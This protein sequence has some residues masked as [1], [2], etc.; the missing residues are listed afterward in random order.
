MTTRRTFLTAGLAGTATALLAACGAAATPTPV[1]PKPTEPPKPAAPA[2]PPT[3]APA[4]TKPAE[5][6]KPAAAVPAA[7]APTKP[8]D[9]AAK[10]TEAAKP[11]AAPQPAAAAPKPNPGPTGEW[12]FLSHSQTE[13]YRKWTDRFFAQAFPNLKVR[14]DI[15]PGLD[16]YFAKLQTLFAANEPFDFMLNHESR[17]QALASKG[18]LL[19]LDDYR[20]GRPFHVPEA[21]LFTTPLPG[22]SWAGKLYGWPC[23][24]STNGVVYNKT[25]LGKGNA[26]L[27]TDTWTV[28]D[29]A[30]MA[31]KATIDTNGDGRPDTWGITDWGERS[32]LFTWYALLR[33]FGGDHF[34]TDGEKAIINE[35]GGVATLEYMRELYCTRKGLAPASMIAQMG[36]DGIAPFRGGV[37]AFFT[38]ANA[39]GQEQTHDAAKKAGFEWGVALPPAGPAGQFSRVGGSSWSIP[40]FSRFPEPSWDFARHHVSD[41]PTVQEIASEARMTVPHFATFEKYLGPTGETKEYLGESWKKVFV[42]NPRKNGVV[43]NYSRIGVEY[44]PMVNAELSSLADCSK[45]AKQVADAIAQKAQKAL[46]DSK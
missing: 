38:A 32:S 36:S 19:P 21:E 7:P 29:M 39:G 27:P 16:Q 34:S 31:V 30:D 4:A 3:T 22:L 43:M 2:A 10:P 6:T 1:P 41:L 5:P 25:L 23:N 46:A 26:G 33:N 17:A 12:V 18:V 13:I 40:K 8:A 44:S 45:T 24:Q 11:A 9:A 20:K 42:D 28:K 14:Y 15:I 35:P 37:G